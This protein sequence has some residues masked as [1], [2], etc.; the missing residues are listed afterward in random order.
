MSANIQTRREAREGLAIM[1]CGEEGAAA[2][3]HKPAVLLLLLLHCWHQSL[4]LL[5]SP[6]WQ[7]SMESDFLFGEYGAG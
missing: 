1:L 4:L 6:H 7:D 3:A 5:R 2:H